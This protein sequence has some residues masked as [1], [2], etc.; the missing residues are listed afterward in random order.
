MSPLSSTVFIIF[1]MSKDIGSAPF[2]EGTYK[3]VKG[4]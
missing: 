2:V 4:Q 3:K 1:L